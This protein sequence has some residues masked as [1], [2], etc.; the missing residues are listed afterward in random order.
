MQPSD[1]G[2][3]GIAAASYDLWFGTEPDRVEQ[4]QFQWLRFEVFPGEELVESTLRTHRLRW[5]HRYEFEIM[6][7]AAGFRDVGFRL[8]TAELPASDPEAEFVFSAHA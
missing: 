5:Y 1:W 3:R 8:G 6:L 7:E 2:Y 4:I